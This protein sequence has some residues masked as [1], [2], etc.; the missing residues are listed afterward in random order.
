MA[1]NQSPEK[2]MA[3]ENAEG[4]PRQY[5]TTIAGFYVV[6]EKYPEKKERNNDETIYYSH[7]MSISRENMVYAIFDGWRIAKTYQQVDRERRRTERIIEKWRRSN[8]KTEKKEA[9]APA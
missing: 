4:L 2:W 3:T 8:A 7:R 9:L 5:S 6:I 1:K